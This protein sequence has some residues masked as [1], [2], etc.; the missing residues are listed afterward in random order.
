MFAYSCDFRPPQSDRYLL[1]YD[2]AKLYKKP[3]LGNGQYQYLQNPSA[4]GSTQA[5]VFA[6]RCQIANFAL[7]NTPPTNHSFIDS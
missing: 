1:L 5:S 6:S 4:R 2:K 7:F 3:Q